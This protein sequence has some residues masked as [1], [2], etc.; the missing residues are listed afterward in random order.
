MKKTP[1]DLILINL[2][3]VILILSVVVAESNPLRIIIGLPLLAFFPGYVLTAAIFPRPGM[4][5]L[6]R[7]GISLALS[8]GIVPVNGLLLNTT[9]WGLS[10]E[11]VMFSTALFIFATSFIAWLRRKK[12]QSGA[13]AGQI[14]HFKLPYWGAGAVSKVLAVVLAVVVLGSAGLL[15][16]AVAGPRVEQKFT[17]FYIL[18]LD[19][20][21]RG[22]PKTFLWDGTQFSAVELD[23]GKVLNVTEG[24]LT[25]VIANHERQTANYL[26]RLTANGEPVK[27]YYDGKELAETGPVS[28]D[29]GGQWRGKIGFAPLPAPDAQKIEF[30]LFKDGSPDFAQPLILWV[31]T[32]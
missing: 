6:K 21:P 24:I 1:N 15:G 12:I 28:L 2:L 32:R 30:H 29:D 20:N 17:E 22:Y 7:L 26:V 9:P 25:L 8:A 13:P 31:E 27:I 16:Y 5:T 3:T 18:G 19:G 23:D 11:S 14:P 4:E 10:F